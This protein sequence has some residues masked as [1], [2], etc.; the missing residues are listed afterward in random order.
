MKFDPSKR[1]DIGTL[2]TIKALEK[3]LFELL[4]VN[5]FETLTIRKICTRSMIPRS[6]FYNYFE[7]KYDLLEVA[8]DTLFAEKLAGTAG[9]SFD[10]VV[11]GVKTGFDFIDTHRL[12]IDRILAKIKRAVIFTA[13]FR[14]IY[15][16]I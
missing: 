9:Y 12:T 8:L 15:S 5:A 11:S 6:T 7:D 13:L 4:T 2:R 1:K 10:S 14:P 3:T 16:I